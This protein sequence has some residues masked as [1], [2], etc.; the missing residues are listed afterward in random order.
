MLTFHINVYRP[1]AYHRP[2]H[3]LRI[4][5][6]HRKKILFRNPASSPLLEPRTVFGFVT[7]APVISSQN[8]QLWSRRR[9]FIVLSFRATE[10]TLTGTRSQDI[11]SEF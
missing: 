8:K 4:V 10:I 2:D 9:S 3:S 7:F 5:A 6:Y 11:F 1:K